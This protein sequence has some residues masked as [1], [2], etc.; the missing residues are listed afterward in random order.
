MPFGK[1]LRTIVARIYF[2]HIPM[3]VIIR[4]TCRHTHFTFWKR[5]NKTAVYIRIVI[6]LVIKQHTTYI[7]RAERTFVIQVSLNIKPT[8]TVG[9]E[10][11]IHRMITRFSDRCIG[12][13]IGTVFILFIIGKLITIISLQTELLIITP[14]LK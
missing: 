5:S 1:T 4:Q 10:K 8:V 3:I 13:V 14:I 11:G 12:K 7:V 2:K 6:I 9:T